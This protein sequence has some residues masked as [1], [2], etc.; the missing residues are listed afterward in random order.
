MSKPAECIICYEDIG[1][2]NCCTTGCGHTF[3]FKC[4]VTA[5]QY[6][7]SCPYCRTSLVDMPEEEEED[8]EEDEDDDE[9]EDEDEEED[10]ADENEAEVEEIVV[11]LQ[12]KGITMSD[13]VSLLICRYS[14]TRET[15]EDVDISISTLHH[16]VWDVVEEADDEVMEQNEMMDEDIRSK[17][18]ALGTPPPSVFALG[19]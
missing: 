6:N 11:R 14:R 7:N 8:E 16:R 1:D 9:D 18:I 5:M 4:I 2:K 15:D 13:L 3:C 17:A 10:E 19:V 12:E